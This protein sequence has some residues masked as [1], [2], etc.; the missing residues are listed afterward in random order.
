MSEKFKSA[1]ANLKPSAASA[2]YDGQLHQTIYAHGGSRIWLEK[3]GKRELIADSFTTPEFSVALF[4]FVNDW[5]N[6]QKS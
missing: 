2:G 4:Y 5:M 6:K 1:D 3:D